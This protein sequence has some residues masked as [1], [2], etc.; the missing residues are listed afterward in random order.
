M[1]TMALD[2]GDKRIG[3]AIS[4]PLDITAQGI[5]TMTRKGLQADIHY[6]DELASKYDVG[7]IVV[8]LPR[9]MNGS[10]GF[11]GEKVK[12]FAGKVGE[13][14]NIP[15]VYYDERLTTV[16]AGRVLLMADVSRMKRK[17][18]VDKLAAVIILQSYMDSLRTGRES[19]E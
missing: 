3:V 9:N 10:L 1:R 17:K 13:A 7:K 11:Q 16:A 15:I 12:N 5:E 18:V 19:D 6:L 4:D 8:G 14:L 2:V